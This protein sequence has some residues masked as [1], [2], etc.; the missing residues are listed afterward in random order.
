MDIICK[1]IGNFSRQIQAI[2]KSQKLYYKWKLWNKKNYLVN[3]IADGGKDQYTWTNEKWMND[4]NCK[5]KRKKEEYETSYL[6]PGQNFKW[7]NHK[8][9]EPMEK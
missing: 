9:L 7:S 1:H 4:P 6:K 3:L 2:E 8:K 5:I